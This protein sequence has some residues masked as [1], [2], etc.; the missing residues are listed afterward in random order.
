M[1]AVYQS[2]PYLIYGTKGGRQLAVMDGQQIKLIPNPDRTTGNQGVLGNG[3]VF[4]DKLYLEYLQQSNVYCI[5]EYNGASYRMIPMPGQVCKYFA[6][7]R[8]LVF[9]NNLYFQFTSVNGQPQT[10]VVYRTW[11]F[12]G[13]SFSPIMLP[14]KE[15][16]PHIPIGFNGKLYFNTGFHFYAYDGTD[17]ADLGRVPFQPAIEFQHKLYL[18]KGIFNPQRQ[19]FEIFWTSFDGTTFTKVPLPDG[20]LSSSGFSYVYKDA[21]FTI[22][23]IHGGILKMAK[24]DGQSYNTIPGVDISDPEMGN[25]G[26]ISDHPTV[27]CNDKIY[28]QFYNGRRRADS[29]LVEYDGA[30]LNNVPA[31]DGTFN[32]GELV[33]YN[34]RLYFTG[35]FNRSE[36]RLAEYDG[37][38]TTLIDKND[39][40]YG[41]GLFE[42]DGKLYFKMFNKLNYYV[43]KP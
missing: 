25:G 30:K 29:H 23:R 22:F 3:I 42:Y 9:N 43:T 10:G 35:S 34:N 15:I 5:A 11:K 26:I 27:V 16:N 19:L 28:F 14:D 17:F 33:S 24:F 37:Q 36:Y 31:T 13:N 39:R 2:K 7:E 41:G 6:E 1:I 20:F 4:H 40:G 38:S 32:I 8:P 18:N 21:L 12:D